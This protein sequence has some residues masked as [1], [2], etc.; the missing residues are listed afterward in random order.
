[1]WPHGKN[2]CPPMLYGNRV[3]HAR[4]CESSGDKHDLG[5][6]IFRFIGSFMILEVSSTVGL[7]L[8]AR[9][10]AMCAY[11][12]TCFNSHLIQTHT[13]D[14]IFSE[15]RF[16]TECTGVGS[17]GARG[18]CAPPTFLIGGAMVRLCP[19]P[20][21]PLPLLTPHFYFPLELYVYITLT[22][23]YLAFFIYQLIILWT[24][25]IN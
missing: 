5:C 24:I 16:I 13:H 23:N 1:M 10:K 11:L 2:N 21:P 3:I 4:S 18:A 8:V 20:P 17:G 19:P 7:C 15:R 12:K 22:N 6:Q 25:S 14:I 9:Q